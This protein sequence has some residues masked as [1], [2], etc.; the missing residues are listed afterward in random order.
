M[1]QICKF[2]FDIHR[3]AYSSSALTI[4]SFP[5]SHSCIQNFSFYKL[6]WHKVHTLMP[7]LASIF[8]PDTCRWGIVYSGHRWGLG[9]GVPRIEKI[10]ANYYSMW[11]HFLAYLYRQVWTPHHTGSNWQLLDWGGNLL[12]I[13]LLLLLYHFFNTY[14]LL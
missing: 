12:W 1:F 8:L 11:D 10:V 13:L 9:V 7:A 3:M 5:G 2:G 14:I 4:L 6:W